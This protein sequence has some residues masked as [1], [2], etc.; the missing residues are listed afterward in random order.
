[1]ARVI[2]GL[3]A[4]ALVPA[5]IS[6]QTTQTF[7]IQ[8]T[9]GATGVGAIQGGIVGGFVAGQGP[10]RDMPPAKT[11]TARIRGRVLAAD[12]GQ[13]VRRASIRLS[14][15]EMPQ[16][17]STATDQDGRYEFRD[18]PAGRYMVSAMKTG[19]VTISFGQRRPNEPG[20]PL[21]L[22]DKHIAEKV[23]FVLPRG[24]IITGRVLDEFGEPVANATVQPMMIRVMNG[25]RRPFPSGPQ[26]TTPD[27][28][29][30]RLWGLSPGD[31]FVAV[32]VRVTN[33]G[34]PSDD[35]SR[36]LPTYYPGTPN[37]AEAQPVPIA[38][39]QT[40]SGVDVMLTP[41][42][43]ARISGTA[44]SSKGQPVRSG[45][46]M[47]MPRAQTAM[48]MMIGMNASG[49]IRPDGTF[50][51]NGVAPGEY[52]LRANLPPTTPGMPA[53]TLLALVSVG[54]EDL[55]GVVLMPVQPT[56]ITGKITLDP[57]SAWLEPSLVRL[58][59]TPKDPGPN[60][61]IGGGPPV[62]HDDLTFELPASP[63]TMMIRAMPMQPGGAATWT[64]KSVRIDSKEVIDSG[65]E[66]AVGRDLTGVEI[67][68]TN[69]M[70]VV[71]GLVT[72][73]KGEIAQDVT[74]LIFSQNAEQRTTGR[75]SGTGRLDQNGRYTVRNLPAGDYFAVALDYIDPN[76]RGSDPNYFEE[77]SQAATR[78]SLREGET[79]ALDLKVTVR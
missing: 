40:A 6:A 72:N 35:R 43:T 19:Y 4:L 79:R 59:A 3:V 30:F 8:G 73:A 41:A 62:V 51:I 29:E 25:E 23:D 28:G 56:K 47:V 77:L 71:S 21:D 44:M 39:G 46:V 54:G 16:G 20:R 22:A 13:P 7:V 1:M 38:V 60:F 53:E 42:H 27:T 45:F 66:L 61:P 37:V 24:G 50:V 48:A 52:T 76:R 36:Y 67:V 58:M 70:Q 9:D 10:A 2:V 11:G 78:F 34:D 32:S 68:L 33:F 26:V 69:R 63:G 65:I 14:S 49:P 57:P 74:V 12:N 55:T 5:F 17:R 18:L 64:M 75:F 31:Y 15:P